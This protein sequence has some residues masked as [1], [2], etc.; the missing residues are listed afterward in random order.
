MATAHSRNYF[1][2]ILRN[3]YLRKFRPAKYK[4]Y[5]VLVSLPPSSSPQAR[6]IFS[7]LCPG[8]DFLPQPPDPEDVVIETGNSGNEEDSDLNNDDAEVVAP[9]NSSGVD[10]QSDETTPTNEDTAS[11][12]PGQST[13]G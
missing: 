5:T 9:S 1:N 6:H 2:E 4:R 8:E 10:M 13:T 12:S 11:D 7:L 3:S